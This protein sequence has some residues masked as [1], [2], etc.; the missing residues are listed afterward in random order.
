VWPVHAI[1]AVG[2]V[3]I[4]GAYWLNSSGRTT[5]QSAAYQWLNLA[6]ALTLVVYGILLD[7]WASV[8]LNAIWGAI[9]IVS[10]RRRRS[11]PGPY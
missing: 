3:L 4:L 11:R 10:L 1:G 5:A 8:A 6:G 7:A 9:A 2:L